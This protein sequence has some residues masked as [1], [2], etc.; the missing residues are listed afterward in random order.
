MNFSLISL[1]ILHSQCFFENC[2]NTKSGG[3]IYLNSASEVV[4]HQFCAVNINAQPI[5]LHSYI[6][7]QA[8]DYKTL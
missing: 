6:Y 1:K 7:I 3:V 4:Q 8:E 2:R 5:G